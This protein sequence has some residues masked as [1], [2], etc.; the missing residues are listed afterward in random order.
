MKKR[1]IAGAQCPNCS[2]L[3]V[4]TLVESEQGSHMHCV[5]CGYEE[6]M[7]D[8][9]PVAKKKP[10]EQMIQWVNIDSD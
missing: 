9:E 3:D 5:E 10:T 6:N 2:E 8:S 1:F 7:T 4:I